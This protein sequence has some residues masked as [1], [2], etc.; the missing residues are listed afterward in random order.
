MQYYSMSIEE[1]LGTAAKITN[2]LPVD[3]EI[4]FQGFYALIMP[5]QERNATYIYM[6]IL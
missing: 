4:L 1:N 3:P 5:T 6:T 2:V